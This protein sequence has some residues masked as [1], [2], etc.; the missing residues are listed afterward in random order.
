MTNRSDSVDWEELD[1][2]IDRRLSKSEYDQL[3]KQIESDPNGWKNCALAFLEHQALE[4]ELSLFA[5]D[6]DCDLL[7][8]MDSPFSNEPTP[9]ATKLA[10]AKG[11]VATMVGW[12]SMA[13]CVMV[14][15]ALG[16]T[17]QPPR[18]ND[19]IDNDSIVIN[20]AA[21]SSDDVVASTGP[22]NET[23]ALAK[24]PNAN[25]KRCPQG[26]SNNRTNH[27][28]VRQKRQCIED[29]QDFFQDDMTF[30]ELYTQSD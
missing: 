19:S 17:L 26:Y 24:Q 16:F 22:L 15:L 23:Q 2:L 8:C 13:V 9:A 14:G 1:R 11:S 12:L 28:N 10:S 29:C 4:H 25:K 6:P 27:L 20:Q 21:G 7:P 5:A 18:D 3:L 30:D